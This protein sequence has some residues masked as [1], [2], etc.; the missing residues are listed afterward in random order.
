M[1]LDYFMSGVGGSSARGGSDQFWYIKH[2]S[3]FSNEGGS[4]VCR[5]FGFKR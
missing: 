5:L 2:M 3:R 1:G 4:V